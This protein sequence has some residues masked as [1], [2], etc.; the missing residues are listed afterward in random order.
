VTTAPQHPLARA[1]MPPRSRAG[2]ALVEWKLPKLHTREKQVIIQK[3]KD[4]IVP[5]LAILVTAF[6]GSLYFSKPTWVTDRDLL[7]NLFAESL[8]IAFTVILIDRLLKQAERRQSLPAR[9]AAYDDARIIFVRARSLWVEMA[10]AA[11]DAPI[12]ESTGLFAAH[13]VDNVRN[14]FNAQGIAPIIPQAVWNA[15]LRLGVQEL[16]NLI[17]R[18]IQRHISNM[19]M[20]LLTCLRNL[21]HCAFFSVSSALL[22]LQQA[23]A[24]QGRY[25]P[26]IPLTDDVPSSFPILPLRTILVELAGEFGTQPGFFMPDPA[27]FQGPNDQLHIFGTSRI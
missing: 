7:G 15:Y 19:D 1:T 2:A 16:Q 12:A 9:F 4:F 18:N 23:N 20:R 14:H 26:R 13:V 25:D 5:I 10:K 17:D 22:V 11:A 6:I 27:H 21:E 3:I 8:G 24:A